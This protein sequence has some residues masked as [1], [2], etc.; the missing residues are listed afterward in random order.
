MAVDFEGTLDLGP[1]LHWN[2]SANVLCN[3]MKKPEFLELILMNQAIIP[4]YVIE[5]LEY[6]NIDGLQRIA[7]PMTCFCDIPFSK[8]GNH[9]T[10]YGRYGIAL[11]KQKIIEKSKVQPILYVNPQSPLADDFRETFAKYYRREKRVNEED[12]VL[13]NYILSTL[14]YMKPILGLEEIDGKVKPYIFQDE[15]EWRYIPVKNFPQGLSLLM[16]EDQ[17]TEKGRNAYS[18]VLKNHPETWIKFE[19]EDV[20]YIIVPDEPALKRVIDVI[21]ELPLGDSKKYLLISKIEISNRFS[22]D[23]L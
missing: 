23:L 16:K 18:E 22:E 12:R 15:C 8:V 11:D 10:Q 21:K 14:L 6:W 20:R 17:I 4:R 19:W 7:F 13:L 5:P 9:M 3:Y 1:R 2:N